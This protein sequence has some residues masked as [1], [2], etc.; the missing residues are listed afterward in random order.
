[1]FAC[2]SGHVDVVSFLKEKGACVNV[3]DKVPRPYA[4]R[5]RFR[6][7]CGRLRYTSSRRECPKFCTGALVFS[8][9]SITPARLA[10]RSRSWPPTTLHASFNLTTR[11]YHWLNTPIPSDSKGA[12]WRVSVETRCCC[13]AIACASGATW[14]VRSGPEWRGQGTDRAIRCR[15]MAAF[16]ELTCIR[17]E[18]GI[19][20]LCPRVITILCVHS[21]DGPP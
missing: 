21:M 2:G 3:I 5:I 14:S 1:M 13:V 8:M 10:Y 7:G 19:H 18:R 20:C 15:R 17:V 16:V 4:W 12:V 9:Q 11:I 6:R